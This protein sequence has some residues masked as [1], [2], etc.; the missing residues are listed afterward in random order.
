M[1]GEVDPILNPVVLLFVESK[2]SDLTPYTTTHCFLLSKYELN[3]KTA[4]SE[5]PIAYSLSNSK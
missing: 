2:N 5:G 4:F 3:H 1:G